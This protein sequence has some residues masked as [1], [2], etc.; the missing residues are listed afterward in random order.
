MTIQYIFLWLLVSER[1]LLF[2]LPCHFDPFDFA[3]GRLREK[4]LNLLQISQSLCSFEMTVSVV[5]KG[6][7]S[8]T[9]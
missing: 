7:L 6:F 5:A 3:Q 8:A 2:G 4:S 1:K 9:T